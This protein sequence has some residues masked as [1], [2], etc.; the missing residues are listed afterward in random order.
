MR[1]TGL[2][3]WGCCQAVRHWFLSWDQ[4][5]V[6]EFA[7]GLQRRF[8]NYSDLLTESDGDYLGEEALPEADDK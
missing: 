8:L 6:D 1:P 7:N 2:V 4:A 5:L 3:A